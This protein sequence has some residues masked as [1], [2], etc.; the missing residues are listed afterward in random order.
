MIKNIHEI[1]SEFEQRDNHRDRVLVLKYNAS[2]ALR[3]ILQGAF[4]PNVVF[5]LKEIPYYRPSGAPIGLG[6]SSLHSEVHRLYLF[7]IGNPKTPPTLT[8]K[9]RKELFIQMCESLEPKEA[10]IL[11]NMMRKDLKVKGLT[12]E[13]VKD[14]FPDLLP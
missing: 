13:V 3:T 4:N 8:D 9:R 11:T 6:Y 7:E 14:A 10:E 1:F 12:Y 5:A 2:F